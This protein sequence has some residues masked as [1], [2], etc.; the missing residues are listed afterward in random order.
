MKHFYSLPSSSTSTSTSTSISR[1]DE[2]TSDSK[3]D[4]EL[5][6][7]NDLS[8]VSSESQS[9][10]NNQSKKGERNE[11]L[12]SLKKQRFGFSSTSP[13]TKEAELSQNVIPGFEKSVASNSMQEEISANFLKNENHSI[14]NEINHLGETKLI[15]ACKK[16]KVDEVRS[17]LLEPGIDVNI[18]ENAGRTA[19]HEAVLRDDVACIQLLLDH[20]CTEE[21]LRCD[22]SKKEGGGMTALHCAVNR[23]HFDAVNIL[24]EYGGEQL[25]K[26]KNEDGYLPY[27]LTED[28]LIKDLLKYYEEKPGKL[29]AKKLR[30]LR[31]S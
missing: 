11:M 18:A 24:L 25:L 7:L 4:E 12:S 2:D 16:S 15:N 8:S 14:N 29:R 9:L 21:S 28:E 27:E 17:L 23:N 5:P 20:R 31:L 1:Y 30:K 10:K 6:D 22:I 26:I 3:E 19:L 13:S